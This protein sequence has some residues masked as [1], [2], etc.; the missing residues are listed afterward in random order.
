[1]Q[2]Y[3]WISENNMDYNVKGKKSDIME[4]KSYGSIYKN[5]K[6]RWN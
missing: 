1:M 2:Q 3:G 5:F 6:N 4:H